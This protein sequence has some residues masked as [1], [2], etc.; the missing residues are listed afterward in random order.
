MTFSFE[1][2]I[3]AEQ[4]M[5]KKRIPAQIDQVFNQ[6]AE[7]IYYQGEQHAVLTDGTFLIR[8]FMKFKSHMNW[9][10]SIGLMYILTSV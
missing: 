7:R 8:I 2:L 9:H 3:A 5:S 4:T 10:I 1:L 6:S